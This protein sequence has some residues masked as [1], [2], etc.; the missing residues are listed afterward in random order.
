[1]L[2]LNDLNNFEMEGIEQ[3]EDV[4]R[5]TLRNLASSADCS[6]CKFPSSRLQSHYFRTLADLPASG[7]QVIYRLRVRRFY[8]HN[9]SCPRKVF[10]ERFPGLTQPFAQRTNRLRHSLLYLAALLGGQA[11]AGLAKKL[12]MPVSPDTLLRIIRAGEISAT[13]EQAP[14]KTTDNLENLCRL[15]RIGID[16]W[17]LKRGVSYATIIIDLD[18]HKVV[19]LLKDRSSETVIEWLK[20]H[21]QL[22]VIS[23]DRAT[24]YILAASQ[25]APQAIQVADRFHLVRNLAEQVE[26][27]LARLRKE[28]RPKLEVIESAKQAGEKEIKKELPHPAS[29][30]IKPSQQTERKRQARKAERVERYQ[31]VVDLRAAGLKQIEIAKRVGISERTVRKFLQSE[32]YPEPQARPKRR[33]KF[34]PYTSYVL[35]RW[36]DGEREGKQLY[37]EIV[38]LGFKGKLR[39]VQRYL[40]ELRDE[41][42]QPIELPPASPIEGLKARRA[43]WWFI[44]EPENLTSFETEQLEKLKKAS[45]AANTAYE[46]VRE[47]MLMVHLKKGD[48]LEE[49][50]KKVKESEFEELKS[51]GRGIEK[52]KAAVEAGLTLK[53]SNGP[54]EGQNN[55]LK[56]I[57][58]T[59]Y[60][61]G[62]LDL[63]KQRL[64]LSA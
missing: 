33:S 32:G 41:K 52:D 29:W 35:T 39:M 11:G 49:W 51:F 50:L 53:Y 20:K 27:L 62:K 14:E 9:P 59:M 47:F 60:G 30:K 6:I 18:S 5:L 43:V 10:A 58:R 1:M 24:E 22:E 25:G 3:A 8:C 48:Q 31:Q 26:L 45:P 28:W 54:T 15:K 44:R 4:V 63:L 55:R 17:S 64:L 21:P 19:E 34:D 13:E 7:L 56:L 37:E 38:G 61:R 42:R 57:R 46:L 36:K 12:G 16:D 40:Q 2:L 23:R